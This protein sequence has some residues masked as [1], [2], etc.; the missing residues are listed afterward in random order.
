M[1]VTKVKLAKYQ[2]FTGKAFTP[3]FE[4]A[5]AELVKLKDETGPAQSLGQFHSESA[6]RVIADLL[7][8]NEK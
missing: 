4:G 6:A 8:L 3:L 7:M 1:K 5:V 2:V